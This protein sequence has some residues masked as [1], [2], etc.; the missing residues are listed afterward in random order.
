[1]LNLTSAPLPAQ[2]VLCAMGIAVSLWA[3]AIRFPPPIAVEPPTAPGRL[4]RERALR[5]LRP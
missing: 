5:A 2:I 4:P 1:M 3:L